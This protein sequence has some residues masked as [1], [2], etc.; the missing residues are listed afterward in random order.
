M[1]QGQISCFVSKWSGHRVGLTGTLKAS[2]GNWASK[3]PSLK[4]HPGW[5]LQLSL[6]EATPQYHSTKK[7]VG[8]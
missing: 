1:I 2:H 8:L 4:D 3:K 7:V 5:E 6:S